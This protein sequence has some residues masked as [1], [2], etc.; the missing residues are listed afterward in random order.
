MPSTT[1]SGGAGAYACDDTATG[2]YAADQVAG[3]L[4][5]ERRELAELAQLWPRLDAAVFF[6][7]TGATVRLVAPL[8]ADKHTDPAVVCVDE[9]RRFA[10]ALTGGHE[11]G[12]NA[13]AT[14]VAELLGAGE[15]APCARELVQATLDLVRGL[16]LAD[17]IT[18]DARRRS[19]ILDEWARVL[20]T[21]L[22]E[23]AP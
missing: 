2:R 22:K 9:A 7:A 13:L 1:N 11:G 4:G 23:R 14:R 5:A 10:V 21:A 12:A 6:L 15:H 17:T 19:R 3:A 20:D 18:D 8:L 16:G